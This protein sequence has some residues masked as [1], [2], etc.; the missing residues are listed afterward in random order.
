MQSLASYIFVRGIMNEKQLKALIY[1]AMQEAGIG[2][3]VMML[4]P[5]TPEWDELQKALASLGAPPRHEP[6]P[7]SKPK[8]PSME[9]PKP[10]ERP[11]F[12]SKQPVRMFSPEEMAVLRRAA[13]IMLTKG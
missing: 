13:E 8:Q 1:E 4:H 6:A 12:R 7:Y 3:N 11:F 9:S 2:R 10:E 5:G